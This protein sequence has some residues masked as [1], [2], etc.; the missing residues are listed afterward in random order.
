MLPI[1]RVAAQQ[2]PIGVFDGQSDV[3][4]VSRR[5]SSSYDAVRQ[6]YTIAGSGG[7]DIGAFSGSLTLPPALTW[8]NADSINA[9]DRS[10]GD[11]RL[12]RHHD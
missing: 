8:T 9:I 6:R 3:G 7:T 10:A 1:A 2:K 12:V 4:T 5:G 11:V